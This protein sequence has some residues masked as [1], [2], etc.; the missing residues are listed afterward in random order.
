MSIE[1]VKDEI[2]KILWGNKVFADGDTMKNLIK[3]K[4][5]WDSRTFLYV[6][7]VTEFL[8]RNNDTITNVKITYNNARNEFVIFFRVERDFVYEIYE[9]IY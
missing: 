4:I 2:E 1:L 6:D 7:S 3:T 5:M 9:K 8:N